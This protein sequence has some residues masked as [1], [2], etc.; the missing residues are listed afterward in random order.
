M[1]ITNNSSLILYKRNLDNIQNRRLKEQM[2]ISTG[3]KI[4]ELSDA[5]KNIVDVKILQNRINSNDRYIN[6]LEDATAELLNVEAN[7]K[8]ISDNLTNV[9]QLAI[10]ATTTGNMGNINSIGV[11]V[12]GLLEDMVLNA[13]ADHNGKFLFSGTKTTSNSLD[14]TAQ[15]DDNNPFE[16]IEGTATADN[17]SGLEIQFKGNFSK[18]VISKDRYSQETI[19]KTADELFGGNGT[20]MFEE[21]I[22]LY[23]TLAYTPSGEKR[24]TEDL[25]TKAE[26]GKLNQTQKQLAK[27]IEILDTKTG[28]SGSI[29]SRFEAIGSQMKNEQPRLKDLLSLYQDTDIA[30][31]TIELTKEENALNYSLQAGSRII[32]NSLFDFLR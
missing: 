26:V 6:I 21:L 7:L 18:R 28:E 31:A 24:D 23:N 8:T 22:D 15:A 4:Q 29:I 1:R 27:Y 20:K 2:K 13:N 10:D 17:P 14:K 5:P 11:Y 30:E 32:S 16:L 25:F 19:N 12:K 9:R 3:K